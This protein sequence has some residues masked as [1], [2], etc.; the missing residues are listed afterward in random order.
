M[1]FSVMNFLFAI[2]AVYTIDIFGRRI[3]LLTTFSLMT[4]F[5]TLIRFSFWITHETAN[6]GGIALSIYLFGVVYSP[7]E[8]PVS[9][10]YSAEACSLYERGLGMC[11]ATATT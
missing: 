2:P 4:A 5:L 10:T 11:L 7:G 6:V 3:L 9:F 1:G 8:E